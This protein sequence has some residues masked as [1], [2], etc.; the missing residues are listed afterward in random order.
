MKLILLGVSGAGKG[1]QAKKL[2][3]YYEIPHISTGDIFR[4]HM[5][6][7]T[8]I[9][10]A[11]H[12]IMDKGGLVEDE[13]TIK[14]VKERIKQDD[15]K[16]GYILDGFPRTLYQ[17]ESLEDFAIIDKAIYVKVDDKVVIE[18]LTGRLVCPKCSAMYHVKNFPPKV[19]GKCDVCDTSLVQREDDKAETVSD[20]LDIF[21]KL[22][23]P[24]INFYEEKD[25]LF[26][27]DGTK[28]VFA[29]KELIVEIL[30][31]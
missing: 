23:S 7:K 11:I 30:G 2:S 5:R 9:G 13:L 20:R 24:I 8:E 12:D 25:K 19:S 4:E 27:V 29:T 18:R 1:T 16:N 15:C 28:D 10:L 17:A 6:D 31:V 3:K 21:H 26:T 14:L 22:T